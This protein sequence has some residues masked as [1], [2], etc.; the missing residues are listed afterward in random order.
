[1]TQNCAACQPALRH[2]SLTTLHLS[3]C[4]GALPSMLPLLHLAL[5]LRLFPRAGGPH[6]SSYPYAQCRRA[7]YFHVATSDHTS[8]CRQ[9]LLAAPV[10]VQLVIELT[11]QSD[12][13]GNPTSLTR[14]TRDKSIVDVHSTKTLSKQEPPRELP[15]QLQ[16]LHRIRFLSFAHST[17]STSSNT[18]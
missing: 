4:S 17:V 13:K 11:S 2:A 18:Q 5:F 15:V 12:K 8:T 10:S 1:M 9:T 6:F 16:S 14:P 3:S 7:V